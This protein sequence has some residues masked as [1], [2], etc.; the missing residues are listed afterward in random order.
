MQVFCGTPAYMSPEI[1]QKGKYDGLKADMWAAGI[2]LYTMLFGKQP[3]RAV[4]EN[5]LYRKIGK[6]TFSIPKVEESGAMDGFPNIRNGRVI[7]ELITDLL[8]NKEDERIS[9][10]EVETK[11]EW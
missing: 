6:G 9:A 1:C 4:N 7:K 10:E 8:K 11:Y 2:I 5:E 3:F